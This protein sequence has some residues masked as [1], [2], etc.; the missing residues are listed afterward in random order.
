MSKKKKIPDFKKATP[1]ELLQLA[2]S[3][4]P[5]IL[6]TFLDNL[7]LNDN[8]ITLILRNP[9]LS[10]DSIL[11]ISQNKKWMKNLW[12]QAA[13]VNHPKTP[14]SLSLELLPNL[15][16]MDLLK[17]AENLR[18][19][20]LVR[21]KAEIILLEKIKKMDLGEKINISRRATYYMLKF[22][23]KEK[24]FKVL[25]AIAE[26]PRCT[27]E[28]LIRT[29]NQPDISQEFLEF[30]SNNFRWKNRYS[31]KLSIVKS[32]SS[33]ILLVLKLL[34]RLKKKDLIELSQDEKQ[35]DVILKKIKSILENRKNLT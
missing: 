14:Q 20:P 18:I 8:L 21:R 25:K 6:D 5:A 35:P 28:I 2:R 31:L 24:N 22:I 30:L 15:Y 1:S 4:N 10:T 11:K 33:P 32:P 9:Y 29:V 23:S 19:S 34:D 12:V 27:E 26:N 7:E 17:V 3:T 13:I 16:P